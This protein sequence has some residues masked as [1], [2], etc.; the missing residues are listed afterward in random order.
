MKL[1]WRQSWLCLAPVLVGLTDA[2]LTLLGQGIRYW[3]GNFAA[4]R[5][6]APHA[7]W[8]L[9]RGPLLFAL[10]FAAYVLI[11][12]AVI[13][14][15][16]VRLSKTVALGLVIGHCWGIGTWLTARPFGYWPTIA[17]FVACAALTVF[18]FEKSAPSPLPDSPAAK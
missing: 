17:F 3:N 12:C 16:P 4:F 15:A 18:T 11:Y 10:A 2:A 9:F 8:L 7:Q 14:A 13:V 5:E 1:N 6:E